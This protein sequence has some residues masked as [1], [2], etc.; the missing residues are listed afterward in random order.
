MTKQQ[1]KFAPPPTRY[2]ANASAQPKMPAVNP[3]TGLH[4]P[5]TRY[6]TALAAQPK[7]G[8][9][10]HGMPRPLP[11]GMNQAPA[12]ARVQDGGVGRGGHAPNGSRIIQKMEDRF[13]YTDMCASDEDE[14]EAYKQVDSRPSQPKGLI[15]LVYGGLG[16]GTDVFNCYSSKHM[17]NCNGLF[18]TDSSGKLSPR[19]K[20]KKQ[21]APPI[22]HIVPWAAMK[23]YVDGESEDLKRFV[24][25]GN[26]DNLTT[27]YDR[28]NSSDSDALPSGCT[29]TKV[30]TY[31]SNMIKFYNSQGYASKVW[32]PAKLGRPF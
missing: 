32:S 26:L 3:G 28:C 10:G 13:Y 16:T 29:Y 8:N 21:K 25:W 14:G 2:G 22:C 7:L 17:G 6:G 12:P 15:K 20:S 30:A 11:S 5:P 19:G 24:C 27:G 1:P 9:P 18:Q 31:V 4:P 23:R